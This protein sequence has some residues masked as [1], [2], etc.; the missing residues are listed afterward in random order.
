MIR[1]CLKLT[2]LF[3]IFLGAETAVLPAQ[4]QAQTAAETVKPA[5]SSILA[6][7]GLV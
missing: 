3:L 4:P 2:I 5:K 1:P 7:L 6:G